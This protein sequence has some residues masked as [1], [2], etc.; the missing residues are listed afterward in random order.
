MRGMSPESDG[1]ALYSQAVA[2]EARKV[3]GFND[4]VAA[5]HASAAPF[6]VRES[7]SKPLFTRITNSLGTAV[8]SEVL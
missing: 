7:L 1:I 3:S 4:N 5:R 2:L 6:T 8:A